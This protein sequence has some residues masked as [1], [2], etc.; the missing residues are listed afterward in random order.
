MDEETLFIGVTGNK[1]HGKDSI[2]DYL[3]KHHDFIQYEFAR[4]LKRGIQEMF[5]FTYEQL[6]GDEKDIIDPI[7]GVTPRE[8][9]TIVGTELLQFDIHKYLPQFE[10]IGRKIWLKRFEVWL[11]Q[12]K[13]K[14]VVVSDVRFK[15]EEMFFASKPNSHIWKI[16]RPSLQNN[17]GDHSSETDV[18]SITYST[19]ILN[20][21]DLGDLYNKI[22]ELIK[23]I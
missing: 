9:L 4:P 3:V 14:R 7:W 2:A 23:I 1:R 16:V 12:V 20:D 15:H 22:D 11:K 6:Y 5:G 13:P 18:A 21:G 19:L 8:I 10:V 17:I